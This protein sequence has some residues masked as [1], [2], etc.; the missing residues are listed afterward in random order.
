MKAT[1]LWNAQAELGEGPIWHDGRLLWVDI[2]QKHLH[3]WKPDGEVKRTIA[4]D[5]E[6]GTVVPCSDGGIL[7]ADTCGFVLYSEAFEEQIRLSE[8]P[9]F[10]RTG[11]MNDGKCD[12]AGRFWVGTMPLNWGEDSGLLYCLDRAQDCQVVERGIQCSNGLAWSADMKCMYYIDTPTRCIDAFDYDLASGRVG[13]RRTVVKVP[14]HHG[15]P[16][17]MTIDE[18]GRLWVGMWGG[19]SVRCYDPD[20]GAEVASVSV[21]APN[22]TACA[23]GGSDLSQLF[24][25][26]AR[27]DLD[28]DTLKKAPDAGGLFVCEPG[29]K[30]VEAFAYRG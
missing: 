5:F 18:A 4:L 12:P 25:T 14:E 6:P 30:G 29:V 24:I 3:T 7:I 26:T 11:R 16:D 22:V 23:F 9:E 19:W 13:N 10:E 8:P 2:A 17:G 15:M 27:I 20:T 21:P 28:E 1:L